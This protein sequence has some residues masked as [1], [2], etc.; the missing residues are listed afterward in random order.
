MARRVREAADAQFESAA[1]AVSP[2]GRAAPALAP[3]ATSRSQG[4]G[5]TTTVGGPKRQDSG[6]TLVRIIVLDLAAQDSVRQAARAIALLTTHIDVLINCAGI[7]VQRRQLSSEG[8]E[9]TFATNHIGPFLLVQELL[10]RLRAAAARRS[11]EPVT[12]IVNVASEAHRISPVRFTDYNFECD[13]GAACLPADERPRRGLPG[14]VLETT[15]G[16]PSVVAYGMSKCANLL[17]SVGLKE[18]IRDL[19]ID[20][21]AVDPGSKSCFLWLPKRATGPLGWEYRWE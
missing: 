15:D 7:N 13:A 14:W 18:Q 3:S 10:P 1:T 6:R 20:S 2:D 21:F 11:G 16:F 9:L 19:G 8:I 5:E 4:A 12:R 17:F